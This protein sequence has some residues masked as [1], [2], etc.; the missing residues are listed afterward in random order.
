MPQPTSFLKGFEKVV[1]TAKPT[2]KRQVIFDPET[3][4]LALII[5]PKGKRTFSIVARSP[6]KKQVWKQ[7]GDPNRLTVAEA[8]GRA[9]EAVARVREGKPAVLP[10][11]PPEAAPETFREVAERF[12]QRWVDKGGKKQDGTPLRSKREIERQLKKYLYPRWGAIPFLEIRRGM[13]TELMDELVDNHGAVQADRVLATLAKMF[14]W[15]RQYDENY[16]SPIIPEM[17]RS[18]SHV[19]RARSRILADEEIR[20]IWAACDELGS[21][22]ALVKVALLTGQRRAKVATM[23]RDHVADR[24]W[25][26]PAEPREKINAGELKLPKLVVEIIEA[27]PRID[28]NP[29]VFAGRG[30]KAFNHFS[31]GKRELD[32]KAPIEPWVM[33]DLRRTARSLMARAGVRSDVAERTLGHVIPGVE[34]VYDRHAYRQEKAE[35]LEALSALVR[36]ILKP[37]K[38]NVV[39]LKRAR[40]TGDA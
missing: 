13:V 28:C 22:G 26:I 18:G 30:K 9:A 27:Q 16:V 31:D 40:G 12:V 34:G 32:A 39:P 29:F 2:A 33:H 15:Y 1:A 10:P 25:K 17:K 19:A 11:A 23:R 24:V 8:R 3:T 7:I 38:G 5:S 36:R 14:N 6:E 37:D 4:G 20:K 21:F 35:A